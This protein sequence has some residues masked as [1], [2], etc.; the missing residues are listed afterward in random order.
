MAQPVPSYA[1][2]S[3][4]ARKRSHWYGWQTLI[5][6]GVWVVGGPLLGTVSLGAG[7][8]LVLGGYF[9]GPPI[10]H[11]SHGEV[12]RGFADLGI[13]VGAPT[14]LGLLGYAALS[15]GS[16]NSEGALSAAGA[17]I[18]AGLGIIAAVVIDASVLAY[19][20]AG[21]E[22][23]EAKARVRRRSAFVPASITPMFAPRTGGGAIFGVSGTL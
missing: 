5:V 19:E 8:G 18:G 1:D 23:D 22:D 14:V 3:R 10:V 17:V 2:Y 12:G 6:D 21:E 15:G 9:L 16:R 20:P 11:W 4:R 7:S 13:R